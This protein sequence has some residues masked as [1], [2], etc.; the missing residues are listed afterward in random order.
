VERLLAGE[1]AEPR[2][3]VRGHTPWPRG[4]ARPAPYAPGQSFVLFLHADPD[5]ADGPRWRIPGIG[6]AGELP[7]VGR[8]V[9]FP[10]LSIA[11][12]ERR[13]ERIHGVDVEASSYCL[14]DFLTAVADY[15]ECFA[16][17]HSAAEPSTPQPHRTCDDATL[18]AYRGRSRMHEYL[19]AETLNEPQPD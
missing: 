4:S 13:I 17:T 19:T 11:F 2:I 14:S 3:E 5:P 9:Y 8:R 15:R 10:Q 18:A 7:V 1:L 12:L 6:G 16:W